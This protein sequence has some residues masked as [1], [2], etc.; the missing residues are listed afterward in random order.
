VFL[1]ATLMAVTIALPTHALIID[2]FTD[3]SSL[4]VGPGPGLLPLVT[5]D[6]PPL[7]SIVGGVRTTVVDNISG[8]GLA[9]AETKIGTGLAIPVMSLSNSAGVLAN[10]A[11]VYDSG[12]AGFGGGLGEDFTVG[13]DNSLNIAMNFADFPTALFITAGDADGDTDTIGPI[14]LPGL[15]TGGAPVGVPVPYALFDPAVDFEKIVGL[16]FLFAAPHAATDI[17]VFF[18]DTIFIPPIPEPTTI[19]GLTLM[20]L[21]MLSQRRRKLP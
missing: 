20:G 9:V 11:L 6:A 4:T 10:M 8:G 19:A 18:L 5:V 7:G 1:L 21:M 15:L 13:G 16:S 17:E 14:P 12:G 3:S 2:D